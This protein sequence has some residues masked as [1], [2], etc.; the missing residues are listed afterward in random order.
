MEG[1]S[2]PPTVVDRSHRCYRSGRK[3]LPPHLK[4]PEGLVD[5]PEVDRRS[6]QS[7]RSAAIAPKVHQKCFCH[8]RSASSKP[9][10]LPPN[11][12]HF[13]QTGSA[14]PEPEVHLNCFRQIRG[15]PKVLLLNLKGI[16][17]TSAEPEVHQKC[18]AKAKV[19][20]KC[21]RRRGGAAVAREVPLSLRRCLHC[22]GGATASQNVPQLLHR[23]R[24]RYIG[25]EATP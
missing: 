24:R 7:A 4:L 17:S 19:Y 9:E 25:Y 16:K 11:R 23:W 20:P 15:A 1:F 14:F 18:S 22:T 2:A 5:A 8:T 10:V 6:R 12:K 13:R 21:F 3:V